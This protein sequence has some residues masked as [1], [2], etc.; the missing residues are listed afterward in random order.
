MSFV[1]KTLILGAQKLMMAKI[2][3][4]E[5]AQKSIHTAFSA[6][7]CTQGAQQLV[8]AEFS[9]NKGSRPKYDQS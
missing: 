7:L 6:L 1:Q 4:F 9:T 3:S 5:G 2:S 8:Y